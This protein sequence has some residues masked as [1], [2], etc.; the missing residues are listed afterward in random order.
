MSNTNET[1][2]QGCLDN[3]LD[4]LLELGKPAPGMPEDLKARIR[5]K[6]I[7][8]G[9]EPVKKRILPR[10]WALWPVAATV[11]AA[12]ILIVLWYGNSSKAIA[13]ADVQGQLNQ[14][15]TMTLSALTG[16]SANAGI[17]I[18][19]RYKVYFK[20]PGLSRTEEYPPEADSDPIVKGPR[21]IT[22]IRRK[23]D[24]NERVTLYPGTGRAE[25]IDSVLLTNGPEPPS[26]PDLEI[27]QFNWELIKKTTADKTKHIGDR[28]IKGIPATGF[29]FEIPGRE[30]V[31]PDSQTHARL[32]ASGKDGT[33][34]LI[35]IEYR[36]PLGQNMRTEYSDIQWNVPLDESLF[37]LA[38]PEGWSLSQIRTESVEYANALLAPG[39]TVQIGPEG[40]APLAETDDV[41]RVV[42]GDQTT[43]PDSDIPPDLR[44]T[45][46][47]KPEAIQRL[48]EY[49][50]ANPKDLI[51]VDFNR[52]IKVVPNLYGAGVSQLSFDLGVLNLS[53]AELE[54][55]YFT[56]TI[57]RNGL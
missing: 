52:Q 18:T 13:W 57:E 54:K 12:V 30:Y 10:P 8:A 51:I 32:W 17:R 20:D 26:Q 23:P 6:L 38:V 25:L 42:R 40:R 50:R 43:H 33:P 22:I 14:V 46:E 15:H 36:D 27:V 29:E 47:L 2:D 24:S 4:R 19:E 45:I 53:L 55:R 31:N 56:T 28:I 21:K 11:L 44:I 7:E 9:R 5:S 35:E 49:A 3:N 48:R 1:H 41:A 16:I 34:L 37:D 39:V